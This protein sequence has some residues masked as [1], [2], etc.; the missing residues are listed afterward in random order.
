[1][2]LPQ[3]TPSSS[4]FAGDKSGWKALSKASPIGAER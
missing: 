1:M 4:I 3:K 2:Y